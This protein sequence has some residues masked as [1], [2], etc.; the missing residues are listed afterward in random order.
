VRRGGVHPAAERYG[1]VGVECRAGSNA[2]PRRRAAR[3]AG[4]SGSR[5]RRCR[6]CRRPRRRRAS[7]STSRRTPRCMRAPRRVSVPTPAR[8]PS[9]SK[10]TSSRCLR[11]ETAARRARSPPGRP[12][13]AAAVSSAPS[14]ERPPPVG[15]AGASAS[16]GTF[17]SHSGASMIERASRPERRAS[18]RTVARRLGERGIARGEGQLVLGSAAF[19]LARS[20][21]MARKKCAAPASSPSAAARRLEVGARGVDLAGAVS[22]RCRTAA[23]RRRGEPEPPRRTARARRAARAAAPGRARARGG[24]RPAPCAAGRQPARRRRRRR[25]APPPPAAATARSAGATH[26]SP[27]I[28]ARARRPITGPSA[29]A[30]RALCRRRAGAR[31][32]VG[33]CGDDVAVAVAPAARSET[34]MRL[35]QV[36]GRQL[37]LAARREAQ[38]GVEVGLDGDGAGRRGVETIDE[39]QVAARSGVELRP[40]AARDRRG[41][42]LARPG[43]EAELIQGLAEIE[44]AERVGHRPRAAEDHQRLGIAAELVQRRPEIESQ[45]VGPARRS[46]DQFGA[47]RAPRRS[48]RPGRRARRREGGH[49]RRRAPDR[50]PAARGRREASAR[51]PRQVAPRARAPVAPRIGSLDPLPPPPPRPPRRRPPPATTPPPARAPAPTRCSPAPRWGAGAAAC[52]VGGAADHQRGG[53]QRWSRWL[54]VSLRLERGRHRGARVLGARHGHEQQRRRRH[55]ACQSHSPEPHRLHVTSK[56]RAVRRRLAGR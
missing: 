9:W 24:R 2:A 3:R 31:G 40:Q 10:P 45:V 49:R 34:A 46:L 42:R 35:F 54:E 11:Q 6:R 13:A 22:A 33:E 16:R 12:V 27:V 17:E 8:N 56:L 53:R 41:K 36:G 55:Q 4:R 52:D 20:A 47:R 29:P 37:L 38:P 5:A 25:S 44:L 19:W 30:A 21:I 23:A 48:V 51:L 7:W 15:V 18:R 1:L 50:P 39:L 43:V 14:D 28:A 26:S 32:E